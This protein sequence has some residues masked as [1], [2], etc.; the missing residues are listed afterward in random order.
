[1][2]KLLPFIFLFAVK[3]LDAQITS[4]TPYCD[5]N[6]TF[7]N[8]SP[9]ISNVVISTFSNPTTHCAQPGYIYYNNLGPISMMT[10]SSQTITIT[11]ANYDLET[12]LKGWIDFNGNNLFEPSEQII[13]VAQG[14][15]GMNSSITKF[16]TFIVPAN[17]VIGTTRMRIA[18]GW[19]F[20]D[21]NNSVYKLDSCHTAASEYSAGETEDYDISISSPNGVEAFSSNGI[22]VYPNPAS[23]FFT[24]EMQ[25]G[26]A[27]KVE[28]KLVNMLGE[29]V[30]S[31]EQETSGTK[32][33]INTSSFARG[34]YLLQVKSQDG[35]KFWKIELQ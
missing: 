3:N 12:A 33:N 18:I 8:S 6:Y 25:S 24:V 30:Y 1:M 22:S 26:V 10:G 4:P 20:A 32:E 15:V 28:L 16:A 14:S 13:Y 19:T 21:S 2:K 34:V 11:L 29:T 7:G 5:L 23:D 31:S 9:T 35:Y 27:G 17:A